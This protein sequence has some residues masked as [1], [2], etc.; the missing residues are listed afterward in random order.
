MFLGL[1]KLYKGDRLIGDISTIERDGDTYIFELYDKTTHKT[2][3]LTLKDI[4]IGAGDKIV[5]PA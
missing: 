4:I 3:R 5:I 1:T 2:D